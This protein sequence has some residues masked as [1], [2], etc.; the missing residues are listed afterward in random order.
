MNRTDK[1]TLKGNSGLELLYRNN[2]IK[3][4]ITLTE[5]TQ[6]INFNKEYFN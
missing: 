1:I 4:I 6:F 2:Y 3:F 5:K